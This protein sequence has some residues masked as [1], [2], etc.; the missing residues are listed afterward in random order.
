MCDAV[1]VWILS[2]RA[3]S[4]FSQYL[5]IGEMSNNKYVTITVENVP[6]VNIRALSALQ[7]FKL[8]RKL[9]QILEE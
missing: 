9:W 7:S 1:A 3:G 6:A 8:D 4:I 5:S 2:Y